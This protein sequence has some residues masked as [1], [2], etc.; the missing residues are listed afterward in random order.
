LREIIE[1]YN[2]ELKTNKNSVDELIYLLQVNG[3]IS[4]QF[5]RG[6]QLVYN[7]AL[8]YKYYLGLAKRK[9]SRRQYR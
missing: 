3:I 5:I 7:F 9:S 2:E 8:L 4:E 1:R 6:G